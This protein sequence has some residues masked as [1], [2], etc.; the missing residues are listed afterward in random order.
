MADLLTLFFMA[1]ILAWLADIK[2]KN[3]PA[4]IQHRS[5]FYHLP[6]RS[7]GGVYRPAHT[8]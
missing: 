5:V 4:E 7:H 3:R 6:C 2:Y 8:L 1:L